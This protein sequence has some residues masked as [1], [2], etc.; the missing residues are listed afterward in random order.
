MIE[1]LRIAPWL[2]EATRRDP[3]GVELIN[4]CGRCMA[5]NS[6]EVRRALRCGWESPIEDARTYEPPGYDGS[7]LATC[8]GYTAALPEVRETAEARFYLDKGSLHLLARGEL[9]D[10]T[11]DAIRVLGGAEGDVLRWAIAN[12]EKK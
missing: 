7:P 12:P 1:G 10:A 11:R 5:Q 3:R 2:Q 9:T 4:D 6:L 8:P